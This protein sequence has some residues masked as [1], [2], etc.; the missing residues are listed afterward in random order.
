VGAN[1]E[2]WLPEWPDLFRQRQGRVLKYQTDLGSEHHGLAP[3][4][5]VQCSALSTGGIRSDA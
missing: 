3:L 4:T 5:G 2:F 1:S